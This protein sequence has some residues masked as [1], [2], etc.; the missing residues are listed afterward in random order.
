MTSRYRSDSDRVLC[1]QLAGTAG[2]H[3]RWRPLTEDE[4]R[5]AVEELTELAAGRTDLLAE[6]AGLL[7]G[8]YPADDV[9]APIKH[10]AAQLLI[11]AGADQAAV[12]G[13]VEEGRRRAA[14]KL[15]PTPHRP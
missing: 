11:A 1:A 10:Q 6:Q 15:R 14:V 4:H 5:V 8:C 13:W 9:F 3:A 2:H 12:E 7:L